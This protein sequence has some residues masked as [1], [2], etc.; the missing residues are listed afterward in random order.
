MRYRVWLG[1]T[2][3]DHRTATPLD[4]D[5]HV[6]HGFVQSS[7]YFY[8]VL[9]DSSEEY[10]KSTS[11]PSL[12]H[13]QNEVELL[14]NKGGADINAQGEEQDGNSYRSSRYSGHLPSSRKTHQ[15]NR[16]TIY[17]TK[18]TSIPSQGCS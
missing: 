8:L 2:I 15:H 5:E 4:P 18:S 17:H 1:G 6:D 16:P 12:L 13:A 3:L 10:L 11:T 9:V 14:L 7:S